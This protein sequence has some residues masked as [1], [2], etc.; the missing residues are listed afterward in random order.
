[1]CSSLMRS[2]LT[3]FDVARP[4][5][6]RGMTWRALEFSRMAGTSGCSINPKR[7]ST[8]P[9]ICAKIF[10]GIPQIGN[11]CERLLPGKYSAKLMFGSE[12]SRR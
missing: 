4:E 7:V 6:V 10:D 8:A 3:D 11:R 5:I 1:M 12:P 2:L 9:D